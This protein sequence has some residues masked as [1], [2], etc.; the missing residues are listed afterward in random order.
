MRF[1]SDCHFLL[2][3]I[4]C[5]RGG[6]FIIALK[7]PSFEVEEGRCS[8]R[9]PSFLW[10]GGSCSSIVVN[11]VLTRAQLFKAQLS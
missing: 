2:L 7:A 3:D 5:K 4:Q 1:K 9:P 6:E 8:L 10:F 11:T